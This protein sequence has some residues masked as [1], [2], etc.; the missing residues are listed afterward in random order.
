MHWAPY[1]PFDRS[2]DEEVV[3]VNQLKDP[4]ILRRNPDLKNHWRPLDE[5][6]RVPARD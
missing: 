5:P 2:Q 1:I 6:S 3:Q 4:V